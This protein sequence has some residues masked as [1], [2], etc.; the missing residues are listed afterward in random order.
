M[1][2]F[3]RLLSGLA[4]AR[5]FAPSVPDESAYYFGVQGDQFSPPEYG[6]YIATSNGVY[7]CSNLRATLV[8]SVPIRFYTLK[9]ED[10]DRDAVRKGPLPE[11]FQKVNPYWTAR[12]L[13]QMTVHSLDLW[14]EAFWY[15]ARGERSGVPKEL[16][17]IRP[18]RM[19]VIPDKSEYIS[20]FEYRKQGWDEPVRYDPEEIFWCRFPNPL[21][22]FSGLS[23]LAAARL[24]ADTQTLAMQSNRMVFNNGTMLAGLITPQDAEQTWTR[25]QAKELE[26]DLEQR[27][28]G[29]SKAHR[30][31]ILRE[32]IKY[33]PLSMSPKDAEFL[34]MSKWN[35]EDIARAYGIPLDLIGGQRTFENVDAATRIIWSHTI[36]PLCEFLADEI[37]EQILPMFPRAADLAEF[38]LSGVDVLQES[39]TAEWERENT[40]LEKMAITINEWRKKRGLDPVPW[41][42]VAWSLNTLRPINAETTAALIES[43]ITPPAPPPVP[44]ADQ[45]PAEEDGDPDAPP[46]PEDEEDEGRVITRIQFGSAEH[47]RILAQFDTRTAG[48]E[49]R[50]SSTLATLFRRQKQSILTNLRTGNQRNVED[51]ALEPFDR[52]KWTK[53]FRMEGRSLTQRTVED[54]GKTGASD[55]GLSFKVNNPEVQRFIETRAQRFA[56][57]VNDTTYGRL[58]ESL[59]EGTKKGE[60]IDDLADRVTAVMDRRIKSDALTIARTEVVGGYNGGTLASWQQ[61]GFVQRKQWLAA[62]D[63]RCRATHVAAHGQEVAVD[64]PFVLG[65]DR[66]QRPVKLALQQRTSTADAR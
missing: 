46:P 50:W 15:I 55:L 52:A 12:R 23:P 48:L 44:G 9:G 26:A 35:L 34:G 33:Q 56:T 17:F 5:A 54:A 57:R 13:L 1:S 7:V 27:F 59:A 62:L 19:T 31:G 58:R 11:L 30:I 42:D 3:S 36:K 29:L 8:S 43:T 20:Y 40:Q 18:D 51:V 38:D 24:A 39:K 53:T 21:D 22:E 61:A 60:S 4:G 63:A 64:D 25:T 2:R 28:K 6:E 45:D 41:G 10:D 65:L 66:D 47:T 37:T 32:N 49:E 16:W 14:G